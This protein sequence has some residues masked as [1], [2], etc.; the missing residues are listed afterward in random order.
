[1]K[2]TYKNKQKQGFGY[3]IKLSFLSSVE[4]KNRS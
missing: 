1:M 4:K 3:L 2:K